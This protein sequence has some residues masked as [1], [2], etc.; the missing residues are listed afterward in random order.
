MNKFNEHV[1]IEETVTCTLEA[2]R[3]TPC[4]Q[5]VLSNVCTAFFK[6]HHCLTQLAF[7]QF[8]LPMMPQL[9]LLV[10]IYSWNGVGISGFQGV[11]C[12]HCPAHSLDPLGHH[13]LTCKHAGNAVI[14]HNRLWDAFAESCKKC[15]FGMSQVTYLGHVINVQ[16]I[17]PDPERVQAIRDVTTSR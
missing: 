7:N 16:G 3:E 6:N 17:S 2:I 13:A 8:H 4:D 1:S 5:K 12:P 15:Q 9:L 11:T 10:S 14:H